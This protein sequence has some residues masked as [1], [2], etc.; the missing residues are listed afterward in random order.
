KKIFLQAVIE[1]DTPETA[2]IISRELATEDTAWLSTILSTLADYEGA[3]LVQ[4]ALRAAVNE[5]SSE[6]KLE[7]ANYFDRVKSKESAAVFISLFDKNENLFWKKLILSTIG[8]YGYEESLP[9]LVKVMQESPNEEVRTTAA[10]AVGS[11]DKKDGVLPLYEFIKREKS[12][13]AKSIAV[14]SM[15]QIADKSVQTYLKKIITEEENKKIREQAANAMED[16]LFILR[17]GRKKQ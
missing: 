16:N 2:K 4:L 10:M 17:Y 5:R 11:L 1:L 15:A 13:L 12:V 9:F 14:D 7:Y 6:R 8:K 3:D